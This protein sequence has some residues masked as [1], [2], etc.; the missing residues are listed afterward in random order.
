MSRRP[1]LVQGHA[2]GVARL[3][4]P[5]PT[6]V[7]GVIE[8]GRAYESHQPSAVRRDGQ[9]GSNTGGGSSR[10][11]EQSFPPRPVLM[12]DGIHEVGDATEE[13][14]VTD[15]RSRPSGATCTRR[16]SRRLL[17]ITRLNADRWLVHRPGTSRPRTPSIVENTGSSPG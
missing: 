8:S 1:A 14:S 4:W 7:P 5:I 11:P 6:I 15:S 17:R 13:R 10:Q 16:L 12:G 3:D 9:V 2:T